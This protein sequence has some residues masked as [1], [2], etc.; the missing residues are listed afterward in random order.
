MIFLLTPDLSMFVFCVY[1]HGALGLYEPAP[2]HRLNLSVCQ[3][4][5]GCLDLPLHRLLQQQAPQTPVEELARR[6][7]LED[8]LPGDR[9]QENDRERGRKRRRGGR[10]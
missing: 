4:A 7:P 8:V 9:E 1:L 2:Q 5:V 3:L 10:V 6:L